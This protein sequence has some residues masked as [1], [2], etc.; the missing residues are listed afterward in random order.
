MAKM[1]KFAPLYPENGLTYFTK[2]TNQKACLS[3][4]CGLTRSLSRPR[5]ITL[6]TF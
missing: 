1:S 6:L 4:G 3:H 5:H 2:P